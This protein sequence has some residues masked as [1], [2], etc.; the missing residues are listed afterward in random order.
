MTR[1]DNLMV[2][3][4]V[5]NKSP[6]ALAIAATLALGLGGCSSGGGG[7]DEPIPTPKEGSVVDPY[8]K[9]AKVFCDV[10]DDGTQNDGEPSAET[11]T[12]SKGQFKFTQDCE[13]TVVMD[14]EYV[15]GLIDPDTDAEIPAAEQHP[16]TQHVDADGHFISEFHGQMKAP[17]G[18]TV[19]SPLTTMVQALVATGVSLEDAQSQ[20]AAVLGLPEGTDLSSLD[21]NTNQAALAASVL[22]QQ[23]TSDIAGA[24]AGSE[25]KAISKDYFAETSRALAK[26]LGNV[27]SSGGSLLSGGT[28]TSAALK[29][30]VSTTVAETVPELA[31]LVSAA[32]ESNASKAASAVASAILVNGVYASEQ[33]SAA[34]QQTQGAA[35]EV[36]RATVQTTA[37]ILNSVS[38]EQKDAFLEAMSSAMEGAVGS[39][40]SAT[41]GLDTI[42]NL[43]LESAG[44]SDLVDTVNN[45]LEEAQNTT[46]VVVSDTNLAPIARNV[47]AVARSGS[48]VSGRLSGYDPNGDSIT[49]EEVGDDAAATVTSGGTFTYTVPAGL[50]DGEPKTFQYLVK[51]DGGLSSAPATVTVT[52]IGNVAP[53]ALNKTVVVHSGESVS[54]SLSGYDPDGDISALTFAESGDN[55]KATVN[56]NGTFTYVAAEVT[57]SQTDTFQFTVTDSDGGSAVGVVTVRIVA[58]PN[59]SPV[60]LNS[61]AVTGSGMTVNGRLAGTD[62]DGTVVG[63]T[64]AEYGDN[65]RAVV[66]AD[67]SYTYTAAL[68]SASVT[69]TFQ[70]N[71]TD[72]EGAMSVSPGTVTVQVHPYFDVSSVSVNGS[73]PVTATQFSSPAGISL[74]TGPLQSASFNLA[75]KGLPLGADGTETV[76]VAARF[77]QVGGEDLAM[78]ID[79]VE[80]FKKPDGSIG[81]TIPA[82]AFMYGTYSNAAGAE[83]DIKVP[84]PEVN[85]LNA[86]IADGGA[87]SL[88][89]L[90]V[91]VDAMVTQAGMQSASFIE[92]ALITGTATGNYVATFVIEGVKVGSADGLLA[93]Q[94]ITVNGLT[95]TGNGITGVVKFPR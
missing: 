80:I 37:A 57:A 84:N 29:S 60:A 1:F 67:G 9:W 76:K 49:Y 86:A 53:V 39:G 25:G 77:V 36:I 43:S 50:N 45:A 83:A 55:P 71:V 85:T 24:L 63:M 28:V 70:F 3:H 22:V 33:M 14:P 21:V 92:S 11:I 72:A 51:D 30:V 38:A 17:K 2:G 93:P 88:T 94:T 75:T 40:A 44:L 78:A 31:L 32:V 90:N 18:A 52:V 58:E 74:A 41:S 7:G 23:L 64:F 54:G 82:G 81:V 48:M 5:L 19:V 46:P 27:A 65:P 73:A 42:I 35:T 59:L 10:N 16:L 87:T 68:E 26:A 15:A 95:V 91:N 89:T 47:S 34:L 69:D 20:L 8:I 12:N 66:S 61:A 6:L 56:P 79:Q 4:R 13:Y 62:P